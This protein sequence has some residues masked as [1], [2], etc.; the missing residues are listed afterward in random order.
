[1]KL[2]TSI[3]FFFIFICLF[4]N[5]QISNYRYKRE[6]VGVSDQWHK[7]ILPVDI[8]GKV[9]QD[10]SD[11]R[12]FGVNEKKDTIEAPYLIRLTSESF[13]SQEIA[14][15]LINSAYKKG[16][17][18][19]TFSIP[20]KKT[21]NEILLHFES[22]NFDW[23]VHLE[24]SMNNLEW[25]SIIENYR[26]LSIKNE[27]L[28][29]HFTKLIF[30]D[31]NFPYVRLSFKSSNKPKLLKAAIIRNTINN[32]VYYDYKISKIDV[33]DDKK[34]KL[35]E[36]VIEFAMPVPISSI[37]IS[38][39]DRFDYYRPISIQYLAD[40]V[41]TEKGWIYNYSTLSS[42]IINSFED[43]NFSF[44][45]RTV[46]KLRILINNFD[47]QA[48]KFDSIIVRGVVHEL[49]VRF[50]EEAQYFMIYGNHTPQKPNYEID[51]FVDKIP[52]NPKVLQLKEELFIG[53]AKVK[54][55]NPLFIS[56]LWLWTI[57]TII[58]IILGWFSVKM[59]LKNKFH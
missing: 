33:K 45:S 16:T 55:V 9:S 3:S 46:Q 7:I 13:L 29:F 20:E 52:S 15:S 30:P 25:F 56:K 24:G 41:K 27:N 17:Y 42:G 32:A 57:I 5:A 4:A 6:I 59:M 23:N 12:I 38:V 37:Q 8:F 49:F 10:F 31:A 21:I 19:Y 47:N 18:Y 44:D 43:N 11:I 50:T 39:R 51:Y 35:S 36:I 53:K 1:M 58:I 2:I 14:F 48:L 54:E 28:D 40:S 34:E 26:I 22:E